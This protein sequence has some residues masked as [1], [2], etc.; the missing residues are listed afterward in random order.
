MPEPGHIGHYRRPRT[1]TFSTAF[2]YRPAYHF[3]ENGAYVN[4][5]LHLIEFIIRSYHRKHLPTAGQGV[6]VALRTQLYAKAFGHA[7]AYGS[8]KAVGG[9]HPEIAEPHSTKCTEIKTVGSLVNQL[10]RKAEGLTGEMGRIHLQRIGHQLQLQTIAELLL[11]AQ[12]GGVEA[13]NTGHTELRTGTYPGT[14][15][16]I[17]QHTTRSIIS[18]EQRGRIQLVGDIRALRHN[19]PQS[20]HRHR[21]TT[22]TWQ[23]PTRRSKVD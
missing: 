5:Q 20:R 23:I 4:L 12:R 21:D 15:S 9:A 19:F 7:K 18:P 13:A 8:T 2:L 10:P 22:N 14:A 17:S 3:E 6:V 11:P 1:G 16:H